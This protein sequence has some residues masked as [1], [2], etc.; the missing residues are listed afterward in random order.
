GYLSP[1]HSAHPAVRR[2]WHLRWLASWSHFLTPGPRARASSPV[3]FRIVMIHDTRTVA[4]RGQVSQYPRL[5]SGLAEYAE[6]IVYVI[7]PDQR[8]HPH[9]E[10]ESA[11]HLREHDGSTVRD[12]AKQH[13]PAART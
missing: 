12:A 7:F 1:A 4:H 11:P 2:R 9:A 3:S 6:R 5:F 8:H 13:R 10:I